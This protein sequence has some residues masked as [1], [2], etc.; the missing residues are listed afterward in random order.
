MMKKIIYSVIYLLLLIAITGCGI[1]NEEKQ[2]RDKYFSQAKENAIKY[3]ESKYG[4]TPEIGSTKCT[5]NNTDHFSSSCNKEIIVNAKYNKKWFKVIIDGSQQTEKGIDNYQYD[6]ITKDLIK[7]INND[8]GTSY[9]YKFYYGSYSGDIEGL[10]DIY[11]DGNNLQEVME[12]TYLRGVVEY[13]DCENFKILQNKL[14]LSN[15]SVFKKLYIV[16]RHNAICVVLFLCYNE[17]AR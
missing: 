9:K 10:I 13:I 2:K 11:Y 4:F 14:T 1:S 17:T 7:F 15:Y 6:L 12:N 5:F 8:F 3:V 16:K